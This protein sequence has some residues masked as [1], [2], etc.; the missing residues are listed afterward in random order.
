MLGKISIVAA[1]AVIATGVVAALAFA[2]GGN[3]NRSGH[4]GKGHG[5][6]TITVIEHAT[7]DTVVDVG[8]ST[9]D[10]TGDQL[11]F[12][13]EVFNKTNT[14]KVGTDLGNCVRI[15]PGVS[16]ECAWT[17]FLPGGQ[18]DVQGPF[19]DASNSVLSITGG[20]GK[21]RNASGQM[22]LVSQA[23]GTEIKFVFQ[24]N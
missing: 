20:T 4:H 2:H 21:Y 15:E 17:T 22:Q 1:A 24:L 23:G 16:Y 19:L 7:T 10:S 3:G 18:I 6:K 14:K 5:G 11:T 9:G 8:T 13:N 12:H